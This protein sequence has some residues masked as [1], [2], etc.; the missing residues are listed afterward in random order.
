MT[1]KKNANTNPATGKLVRLKVLRQD[2]PD[3]PETKRWEEFSIEATEHMTVTEALSEIRKHPVTTA[4]F[5]VA[6]V[7]WESSCLQEVC[8]SC[9]MR[10]NGKARQACG[11]LLTDVAPLRGPVVLEPLGKFPLIRDLVVNRRGVL[12]SFSAVSAWVPVDGSDD[13]SPAPQ[14]SAQQAGLIASL[15]S[16]T[17]CGACLDACPQFGPH[18]EYVGAAALNQV[19]LFN[20]RPGSSQHQ[21]SRT[22]AAMGAGGVDGCGKAQN[23]VHACPAGI[24]LVD[25]IQHVGRAATRQLFS[26]WLL[27]AKPDS[28]T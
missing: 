23:C 27:R 21:E 25:S 15:G 26:G 13:I 24:P 7:A 14:L 10:I 3:K 17:A 22:E 6:P 11:V 5:N 28:D 4:G 2:A 1:P 12:E 18:S 16:C 20:L 8:G 19:R 9:T